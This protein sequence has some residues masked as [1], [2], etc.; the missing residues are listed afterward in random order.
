M[1]GMKI[2]DYRKVNKVDF[3]AVREGDIIVDTDND[4]YLVF[5]GNNMVDCKYG[6]LRIT[7]DIIV[8]EVS[9][10]GIVDL[11][12]VFSESYDIADIISKERVA[13]TVA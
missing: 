3:S 4:M 9:D 10:E 13:I 5:K 12:D 11:L 7:E 2:I 6:L 1:S 8:F